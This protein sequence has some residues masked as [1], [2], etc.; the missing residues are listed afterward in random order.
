[1][2][3]IRAWMP[4]KEG[5]RSHKQFLSIVPLSRDWRISQVWD[6][7]ERL[8]EAKQ[9][10]I[11][12]TFI[13]SITYLANERS[14]GAKPTFRPGLSAACGHTFTHPLPFSLVP[15]L[16]APRLS[17]PQ[18]LSYPLARGCHEPPLLPSTVPSPSPAIQPWSLGNWSKSLFQDGQKGNEANLDTSPGLL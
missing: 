17:E 2:R 7:D 1:M 10:Q 14:A 12:H 9:F 11:L 15:L 18:L 4:D 5:Q 8:V 3:G 16:S 13:Q 6:T